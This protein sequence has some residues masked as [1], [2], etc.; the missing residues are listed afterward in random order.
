MISTT[1][2]PSGSPA[3]LLS[4]ALLV[5]RG[6]FAAAPASRSRSTQTVHLLPKS[7]TLVLPAP[8]G[9]RVDCLEG[10]VWITLDSDPRDVV[11]QAGQS[12][13]VD[14]DRRALVHALDPVRVRVTRPAHG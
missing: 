10:C 1:H 8:L 2:A 3:E 7:Q 14:R 4:K 12:F 9:H 13:T 11:L 5:L 6:A